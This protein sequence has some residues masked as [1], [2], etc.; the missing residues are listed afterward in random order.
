[1]GSPIKRGSNTLENPRRNSSLSNLLDSP[2]RGGPNIM[3]ISTLGG[4][5]SG[6][7]TPQGGTPQGTLSRA[8]QF[9]RWDS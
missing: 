5:G 1:M 9:R 7:A 3:N 4:L 6:A 2:R 8:N